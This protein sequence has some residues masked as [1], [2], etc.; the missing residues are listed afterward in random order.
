MY[1]D[2]LANILI[3][4]GYDVTR[5]HHINDDGSQIDTLIESSILRYQEAHNG[6]NVEI[7]EGL[8]PGDYLKEVGKN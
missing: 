4:C 5:E 6:K 8:C 2:V 3:K 7:P 1:G